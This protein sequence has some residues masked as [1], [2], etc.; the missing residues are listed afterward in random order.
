MTAETSR[1][2]TPAK[3]T[4]AAATAKS[5]GGRRKEYLLSSVLELSR[6][7]INQNQN[8]KSQKTKRKIN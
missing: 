4:S 8:R 6:L 2:T 5:A 7:L 1:A 3:K